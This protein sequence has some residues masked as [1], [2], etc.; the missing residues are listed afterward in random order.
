MN[1]KNLV[2]PANYAVM[3][4]EEMTYT[5]GGGIISSILS[6]LSRIFNFN[7][8]GSSYDS[9]ETVTKLSESH[10]AV[11]SVN[12]G[13][14][15]FSDGYEYTLKESHGDSNWWNLD[16]GESLSGLSSLTRIFGL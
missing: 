11:T 6:A 4:E 2:M 10:G 12:N 16:V 9:T 5:T 15:T 8:G 3:T 1:N 14:Y 7:I 13:V